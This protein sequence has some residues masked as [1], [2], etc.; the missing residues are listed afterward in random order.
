MFTCCSEYLN[1][2]RQQ[3]FIVPV[4]Y[5]TRTSIYCS[6]NRHWGTE[7]ISI[8]RTYE[9]TIIQ[10][11]LWK[12][13]SDQKREKRKEKR[14]ANKFQQISIVPLP[15]SVFFF[16][17]ESRST[18]SIDTNHHN[19]ADEI[20][21]SRERKRER[22]HVASVTRGSPRGHCSHM[23]KG[24]NTRSQPNGL[25]ESTRWLPRCTQST[26]R[27]NNPVQ[28]FDRVWMLVD[29]QPEI[30]IRYR[31]DLSSWQF[32]NVAEDR[33]RFLY[34]AT[35]RRPSSTILRRP[36]SPRFGRRRRRRRLRT[37][38]KVAYMINR[39]FPARL[40]PTGIVPRIK[41]TP[42]RG[43]EIIFQT[44]DLRIV[45]SGV[46]STSEGAGL[47]K[48]FY[49]RAEKEREIGFL[50]RG[51]GIVWLSEWKTG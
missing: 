3:T 21:T 7:T 37:A 44:V 12:W 41:V 19:N 8:S 9:E 39:S 49:R 10:S 29:A 26:A 1:S 46:Q 2:H 38:A 23:T 14:L 32:S 6:M 35:S 20:A 16:P 40:G 13:F 34:R 50:V 25:H 31:R 17:R 33:Y 36:A 4:I 45:T 30:Y 22:M 43:R 42:S 18:A 11:V 24:Q 5:R 51:F 48:V 28:R 47:S 27:E 15:T